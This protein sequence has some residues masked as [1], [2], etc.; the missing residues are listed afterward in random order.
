MVYKNPK[1][2]ALKS[3]DVILVSSAGAGCFTKVRRATRDRARIHSLPKVSKTLQQLLRGMRAR[4]LVLMFGISVPH[5][6]DGGRVAAGMKMHH[7]SQHTRGPLG[8]GIEQLRPN[9]GEA[10]ALREIIE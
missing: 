7:P 3:A 1:E 2:I 5:D 9:A 10:I 8:D 6:S 4:A